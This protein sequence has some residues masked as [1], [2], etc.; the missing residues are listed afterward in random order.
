MKNYKWPVLIGIA[1]ISLLMHARHLN[2]ELISWHVW[3][4]TQTQ[5][6]IINFYEEDFNIL[7]PKKNDRG[8][9]DGS[10]RMEFPLMQWLVAG[11]YKIF[12]NHLI[13]TRLFMFITGLFTVWGMY[14]MLKALFQQEK[15]AL[16]GAWAF[17]FSPTFFYF[18]INPLPD[19]FALCCSIWG[20]AL[21]FQ[22]A[23]KPAYSRLFLSGVFLSI[24]TLCKLPFI[25]YYIVPFVYLLLQ[26]KDRRSIQYMHVLQALT[27]FGSL[28]FPAMWYISVIPH[29]HGNGITS[30][31]LDNQ[32][33]FMKVLD[34]L[35][36]NLV[37]TLPESL[38]NYGSVLFF[39][40]GF[41]FMFRNKAYKSLYFIVCLSLSLGVLAY[42]LFEIN[43]I[44][45]VHDYYLFP[46]YPLLFM[47]VAYGAYYLLQVHTRFFRY[48]AVFALVTLPVWAH[49]RMASRW[50]EANP[51]FNK[52]WL[53]YKTELRNAVPKDALCIAG[54]DASHFILLYYIDKKGW[55]FDDS[56]PDM[57]RMIQE[58]AKY[59]Y[60]DTTTTPPG[61]EI[62]AYTDRLVLEKG[63]M[64]VYQLKTYT[65]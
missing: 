56:H 16:I 9:G 54:N 51:G 20:L 49:L 30:G 4:Q 39:V 27:V 31:V 46:F 41:Y 36:H 24:G 45:T 32:V 12:G 65:P 48:L 57:A 53:V 64:Q 8:A 43:M 40:A 62:L 34:Y 7:H 15:L 50:N 10:F 47:L 17:N 42:F 23:R 33:P 29:W 18:T 52:D 63:S 26:I 6:T 38:L 5:S 14:A 11:L 19:N 37:S 1:I 61:A 59:L 44:S 25:I 2:K 22:W 3:R 58:G 28:V 21:F 13:I 60:L 35:Q 55:C